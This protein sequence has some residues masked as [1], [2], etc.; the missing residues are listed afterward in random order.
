MAPPRKPR[1]QVAD[2]EGVELAKA[3][4]LVAA[5]LY[6]ALLD[7]PIPT[8]RQISCFTPDQAFSLVQTMF[9]QAIKDEEFI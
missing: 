5:E 9:Y 3:M 4:A 2:D 8:A 6:G 1:S 7:V